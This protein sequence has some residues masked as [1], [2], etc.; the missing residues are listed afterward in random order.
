MGVGEQLDEALA[1]AVELSVFGKLPRELL[2]RVLEDHRDVTLGQGYRLMGKDMPAPHRTGLV[3]SGLLRMYVGSTEGRQ[4]NFRYAGPGY[5]LGAAATVGNHRVP[6]AAGVEAV[7]DSRVL[8][9]NQEQLRALARSEIEVAWALLE[10]MVVYQR[11]VIQV[12]AGTAFGSIR[13]RVAM[14]LLNL[15]TTHG[16]GSPADGPLTAPVTQQ[17]LA[18]AVGTTRETV[19]RALSE[20][21]EA[22]AIGT[23]R[24]EIVLLRPEQLAAETHQVAGV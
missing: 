10:Q 1:R 13:Q 24:N 22:G 18:D 17:T 6:V 11:D 7:T 4:V 9:L 2:R 23:G 16:E 15:G 19:A 20:L 12:L 14:H 21:R 3:V 8:Y 5:F